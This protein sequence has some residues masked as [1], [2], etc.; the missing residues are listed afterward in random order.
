MLHS[1]DRSVSL[2]F[3]TGRYTSPLAGAWDIHMMEATGIV[4]VWTFFLGTVVIMIT[5]GPNSL[6]V[7]STG[8]RFG[9]LRGVQAM[10]G[11]F[12]GD[13]VL[14]FL[15]SAGVAATLKAY[16]ISYNI[17]RYAGA[18]YIG[19]LGLRILLAEFKRP[20][21]SA[22]VSQTAD[23]RIFAKSFLVSL[24]NPNTILFYISFFIQFV[25]PA[26]A[27]K[28]LSFFLLACI[29][30]AVSMSYLMLLVLAGSAMAAFFRDKIGILRAAR[31]LLGTLFFGFGCR[32]VLGGLEG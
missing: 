32:L 12:L 7:L 28:G 14:M 11:I 5:P 29:V 26:F 31:L 22:T 20:R 10:G 30:Q 19:W 4:N 13:A 17:I 1:Q 21:Q 18:A 6:Y 15:A 25:D 2:S 9:R 16:P 27:N 8:T 23:R 3:F 24:S